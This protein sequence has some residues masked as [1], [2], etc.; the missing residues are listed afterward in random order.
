MTS[1]SV[2]VRIWAKTVIMNAVLWGIG[3]VVMEKYEALFAAVLFLIGGLVVTLPL[4]LLVSPLVTVST[5]LPY[6][7]PARI[8]W[9][10]FC[11]AL[12]IFI[13]YV[14]VSMAID[15]TVFKENSFVNLLLASTLAGLLFAVLTTNRSLKK[16]YSAS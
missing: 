11:L 3:A 12:L 6:G 10:T 8:A 1:L 5:R 16:L 4:L 7:M 9:L 2:A 14:F 15:P 13:I